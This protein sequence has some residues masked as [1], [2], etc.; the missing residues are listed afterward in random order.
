MNIFYFTVY[1]VGTVGAFIAIMIL[2]GAVLG[3]YMI[4][5]RYV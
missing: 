4:F 2:V 5:N 3:T 1:I